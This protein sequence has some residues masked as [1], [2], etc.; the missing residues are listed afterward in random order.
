VSEILALDAT[1]IAEAVRGRRLQAREVMEATLSATAR[2]DGELNCFT[3]VMLA[4][5]M[6][7][8][9]AVDA[10]IAAGEDA[11]PLAGVPFAAKNLFDIAGVTTLAGSKILADDPPARRDAAVVER[12]RNAG[13]CL[14]GATNM[15]EFAYGFVTE[16]AH[17]G[18]TRNPHDVTRVAGGSSGG[19]AAAV[20]AELVP[21]ALGSDTNGSIRVPAAFCGVYGLKATYGRVSRAGTFLFSA[22]LDHVGPFARSVRDISLVLDLLQGSDPRDPVCSKRAAEAV[23]PEIERGS[24]GLRI[25]VLGGYFR[26]GGQAEVFAAVDKAARA[27]GASEVVELPDVELARAAAFLITACEGGNLH[28]DRLRTRPGDF[29]PAVVDRLMAGALI[30][31][32]WYLH[33]QRFRRVFRERVREVFGRYDVLLAPTTPCPAI[34]VGQQTIEFDGKQI[35]ARPNLGVFTQPIS[36]LG[37][38]VVAAP[39]REAGKLP[40]GVQIIGAPYREANVLRVARQLE[41]RASS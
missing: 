6:A 16:N 10:R 20:A 31:A 11:G 36:F 19:S 25:A 4:E 14:V 27:L 13:A 9:D 3:Q 40:L 12:L 8:A 1:A 18:T 33:A 34:Q 26:R 21:L 39:V 41:L 7:A 22:S 38:P 29:D 24:Q 2:R 23:L 30:P 17:Y 5:A 32:S 15:D 35:P 37:L 28:L